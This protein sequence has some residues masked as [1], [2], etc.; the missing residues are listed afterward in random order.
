MRERTELGGGQAG[1]RP[2]GQWPV[3]GDDLR[4]RTAIDGRGDHPGAAVVPDHVEHSVR[5]RVPQLPRGQGRRPGDYAALGASGI[6]IDQETPLSPALATLPTGT[7]SQ[8]T[9][10]PALLVEGGA[11][12]AGAVDRILDAVRGR[13]HVFNLG[14]GITKETPVEN[15]ARLLARVRAA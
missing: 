4:Q 13:P 15:V 12:L 8:G 9:L 10:D 6:G 2:R 14:H 7:A 3:L 1:R 11:A 5:A